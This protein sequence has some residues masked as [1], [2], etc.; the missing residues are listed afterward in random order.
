M[1]HY[2]TVRNGFESLVLVSGNESLVSSE[3][4][5]VSTAMIIV[6]SAMIV[7][8]SAMVA[9]SSTMITVSSLTVCEAQYGFIQ[10][11]LVQ[12]YS[13][14]NHFQSV[15]FISCLALQSIRR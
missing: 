3:M 6:S 8:S 15:I 2:R 12:K 14:S 1:L 9:I 4:M 7:G 5:A 13:G 10:N 11:I